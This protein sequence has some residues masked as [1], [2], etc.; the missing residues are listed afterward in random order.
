MAQVMVKTHQ[1]KKHGDQQ[2]A[3]IQATTMAIFHQQENIFNQNQFI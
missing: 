3:V 2:K 1:A